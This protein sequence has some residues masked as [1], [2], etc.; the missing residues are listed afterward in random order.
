[1]NA[2]READLTASVVAYLGD[3]LDHR[4]QNV[5]IWPTLRDTRVFITLSLLPVRLREKHHNC[6]YIQIICV[7]NGTIFKL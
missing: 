2:R 4:G 5:E 3:G 7:S 1:M 6:N